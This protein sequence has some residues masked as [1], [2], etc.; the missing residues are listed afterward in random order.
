MIVLDTYI[1]VWGVHGD[2]RLTKTQAEV[3]LQL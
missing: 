3:I 2:E 1:W